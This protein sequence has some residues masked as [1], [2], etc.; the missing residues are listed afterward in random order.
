MYR[1]GGQVGGAIPSAS[2]LLAS[3]PAA[4]PLHNAR[5][6]FGELSTPRHRT[7]PA[8]LRSGAVGRPRKMVRTLLRA[9]ARPR[10]RARLRLGACPLCVWVRRR[11]RGGLGEIGCEKAARSG[12]QA[13]ASLASHGIGVAADSLRPW[14]SFSRLWRCKPS[15]IRSAPSPDPAAGSGGSRASV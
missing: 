11:A 12:L 13:A 3:R 10:A 5:P 7:W 6:G 4:R 8:K 9:A 14:A 2:H 1:P 15:P